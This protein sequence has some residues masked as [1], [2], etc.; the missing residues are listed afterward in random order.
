MIRW[1]IILILLFS[2]TSYAGHNEIINYTALPVVVKVVI[3]STIMTG[4][5]GL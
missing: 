4:F 1:I 3:P 5:G 2:A